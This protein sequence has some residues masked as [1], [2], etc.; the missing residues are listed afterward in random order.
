MQRIM[1]QHVSQRDRSGQHAFGDCGDERQ[2]LN[3]SPLHKIPLA[4]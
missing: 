3:K 1:S 2:T 4:L